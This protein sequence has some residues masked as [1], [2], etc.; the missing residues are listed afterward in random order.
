LEQRAVPEGNQCSTQARA[1]NNR[2]RTRALT[3]GKKAIKCRMTRRG[4]ARTQP[5]S[6]ASASDI[7]CLVHAGSISEHALLLHDTPLATWRPLGKDPILMQD[8]ALN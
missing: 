2:I 5:Q 1:G 7:A 8:I 6:A 3:P 4:S